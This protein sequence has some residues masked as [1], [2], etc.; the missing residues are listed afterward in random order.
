MNYKLFWYIDYDVIDLLKLISNKK[1]DDFVE[2]VLIF[3][4]EN[5]FYRK[6][7][8]LTFWDGL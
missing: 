7:L 4:T 2:Y 6:F 1:Y 8:I 3:Y 5:M